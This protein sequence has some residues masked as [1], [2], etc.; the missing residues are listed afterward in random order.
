MVHGAVI[1]PPGVS[2]PAHAYV[3]TNNY[4]QTIV[5]DALSNVTP[6]LVLIFIGANDIGRGRDPYQVATNDMPTLLD[7]IFSKA[8]NANVILAKTTSL[9]NANVG[10]L[11]YGAF[12][13][14]VS[15]YNNALQ[16][17]VNHKTYHRGFVAE[18]IYQVPAKAPSIERP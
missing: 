13:T 8:P 3:A 6:D 5:P 10:G 14:N 15:I 17:M 12:S 2:G 4:L 11:N 16:H 1:A 7:I 9:M 18:M